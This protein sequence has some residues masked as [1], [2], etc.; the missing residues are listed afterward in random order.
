MPIPKEMYAHIGSK[1]V[2]KAKPKPSKEESRAL[3]QA[4]ET[5]DGVTWA[6]NT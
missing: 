4:S 6:P 1:D 3:S 2:T 5:C